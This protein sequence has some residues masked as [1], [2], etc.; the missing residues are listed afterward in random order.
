MRIKNIG[1]LGIQPVLEKTLA[2]FLDTE[3]DESG[4]VSRFERRFEQVHGVPGSHAVT[5]VSNGTDALSLAGEALDIGA[6]D[7]AVVPGL[8]WQATDGRCVWTPTP[9]NATSRSAY[10]TAGSCPRR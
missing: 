4:L 1:S 10:V 8:T 2:G 9:S 3:R 7:D 6:D 5:A